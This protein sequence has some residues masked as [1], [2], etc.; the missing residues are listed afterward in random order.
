MIK[1][2]R[3]AIRFWR[4]RRATWREIKLL[5]LLERR[6]EE[7]ATWKGHYQTLQQDFAAIWDN[8]QELKARYA[9]LQYSRLQDFNI[10]RHAKARA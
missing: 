4:F 7:L 3:N 2:I 8:H 6:D 10:G 5:N 9:D 1:K